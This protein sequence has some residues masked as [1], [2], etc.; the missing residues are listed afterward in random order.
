MSEIRSYR[1][2]FDLERRVYSVDRLRLN[3]S[4]VPVRGV[5]YFVAVVAGT[6]VCSSLPLLGA[7]LGLVPWYLRDLLL[8]GLSATFMALIRVEGRTFHHAAYALMRFACARRRLLGGWRGCGPRRWHPH[9]VLALPDG[10]ERSFRELRYTGPGAVLLG[11]A[12]ERREPARRH[13]HGR[14][15]PAAARTTLIVRPG[16]QERASP[17]PE[18]ILLEPGATLRVRGAPDRS[19]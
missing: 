14:W 15:M 12:H 1:R 13:R 18:V 10:S 5:A 19:A 11:A 3:P 8:P 7:G 9:D 4:G 17:T 16:R 2:V 6:L